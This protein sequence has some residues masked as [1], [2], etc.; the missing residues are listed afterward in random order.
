MKCVLSSETRVSFNTWSLV[1]LPVPLSPSSCS[2]LT[3]GSTICMTWGGTSVWFSR[4]L[5]APWLPHNQQTNSHSTYYAPQWWMSLITSG[6]SDF[7][8]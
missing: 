6:Y 5:C 7:C 4:D 2:P 8:T 1:G 3:N